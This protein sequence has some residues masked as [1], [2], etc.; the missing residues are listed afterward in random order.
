MR[1]QMISLA[2]CL[3]LTA[4]SALAS[5][6]N[7][8]SKT[9]PRATKNIVKVVAKTPAKA[10]QSTKTTTPVANQTPAPEVTLTPEQAAKKRFEEKVAKSREELYCKL[11][12]TEEQKAKAEELHQKNKTSAEPLMAELHTEKTKLRDLEASKAG[13]VKIE[14][15]K[16]KVKSAKKALKAHMEASR[17]DFEA[18]LNKCQLAKLKTLKEERKEQCKGHKRHHHGACGCKGEEGCHKSFESNQVQP[19]ATSETAAPKCPCE[20][21]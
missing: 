9:A 17:K 16:I 1:K 18:I 15:Q 6:T 14:E 11:G 7:T 4:T 12:L 19:T 21:K 8:V 2:M 13:P 10:A 3:A 5:G 20:S